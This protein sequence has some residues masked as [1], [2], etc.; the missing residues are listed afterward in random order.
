MTSTGTFRD[1]LRNQR[2]L[3]TGGSR[4]LGRAICAA[5]AEHGADVA[6]T[7]ASDEAGA[8]I[9][10]ERI[11]AAGR[12]A[13]AAK[14][15]VLDGPGLDRFLRQ[16]E[17]TWGPLDVLIANAGI[18][19]PLPLA[20]L[21][22][23]DWDQVM[24]TNTKGAFITVRS[25]LRGMIR[26][27]RGAV[28]L[29]GSVAGERMLEAPIHYSASKA[30]LSSMAGTLC[31]EVGRYGIRV[32]CLAPGLLDEGVG[33]NLPEHRLEEYLDHVA[34]HRLGAVA[35]VARLAV[36]LV[37]ARTAYMSGATVVADGGL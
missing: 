27:R 10:S 3:V 17:S 14:V 20:L 29:I 8:A 34:L 2:V 32:N 33:Q 11:A 12:R 16:V 26:R 37:S 19:Q 23:D 18:S 15:P 35:E 36:F 5:C 24:D 30:A 9:T 21:E 4:G 22:E 1:L 28:L 31:K 6:F 7:F 13:V 25:V